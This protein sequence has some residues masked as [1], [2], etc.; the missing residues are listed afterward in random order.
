MEEELR[1]EIENLNIERENLISLYNDTHNKIK[2]L[3][4]K[5]AIKDACCQ[6]IMDM[7][8]DYDGWGD[9]KAGLKNLVDEL[10]YY[11]KLGKEGNDKVKIYQNGFDKAENILMEE[12]EDYE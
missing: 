12:I 5:L 11:A 2:D 10:V 8:F 3:E 4:R 9:I 1:N 7:G 6:M